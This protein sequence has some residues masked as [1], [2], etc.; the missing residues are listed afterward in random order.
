MRDHQETEYKWRRGTVLTLELSNGKRLERRASSKEIRRD[1]E[2]GKNQA[3]EE[4][5]TI[6]SA[7][8][9]QIKKEREKLFK[10]MMTIG[11]GGLLQ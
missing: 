5:C 7:G 10:K 4:W 1:S 11:R 8:I 3:R 2:L 6:S 9:C